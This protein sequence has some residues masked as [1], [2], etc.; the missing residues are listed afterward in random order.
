MF[1]LLFLLGLACGRLGGIAAEA[2]NCTPTFDG[3]LKE[4]AAQLGI[5][6]ERLQEEHYNLLLFPADRD[7]SCLVRCIGVLLRFWDDATGLRESTIRQYYRP[8]D[9]DHCYRNR[10]QRCLRTFERDTSLTDVC[11]RAHRAFLCYH[12][13]YGY[14][15]Q[16]NAYIPVTGHEM[17]QVQQDCMD[18]LGLAPSRLKQYIEGYFPDDPET[19]CFVRCV[20]L[21]TK[22]YSDRTG[23]NVDRL[24]IQCESCLDEKVFKARANECIAAQRREKLSKCTGAYR[25][26]YHCFRDDQLELYGGTTAP[27][28]QSTSTTKGASTTTR[29][30]GKPQQYVFYPDTKAPNSGAS[31]AL[32]QSYKNKLMFKMILETLERHNDVIGQ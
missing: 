5:S 18:I 26:L 6:S 1:P 7:T 15:T 30:P 11:E 23:P 16:D 4:C 2:K 14:L 8:A 17:R 10:T 25:T 20:G 29:I 24:Y 12:Q 19:H 31:N 22:L 21:R 9:E 13:Q 32:A 28:R 3:A 27:A